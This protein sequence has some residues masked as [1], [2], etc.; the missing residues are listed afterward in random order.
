[1]NEN[2]VIV[3]TMQG[4]QTGESVKTLNKDFLTHLDTLR[5]QNKKTLA[6]V[7]I[8]TLHISDSTSEG[9]LEGRRLLSDLSIDA[10]AILGKGALAS[11]AL[12]VIRSSGV[13]RNVRFF[14]SKRKAYKWLET[15]R[16]PKPKPLRIGPLAGTAIMLIG[17]STLLGWQIHNSTLTR[18]IPSL[19]PMNPLSAIG[20]IIIGFGFFA[21][22]AKKWRWLHWGGTI[23]I[24]LGLTALLPVHSSYLLYGNRL[25]ASGA[26][27][28]VAGSAALC[29]LAMGSVAFLAG[30]KGRRTEVL[31]Y[32]ATFIVGSIA[33]FNVFGQLYAHDFIYSLGNFVMAWNLAIAFVICAATLLLL[34]LYRQLGKNVLQQVSRTGWLVMLALLAVQTATY[35]IWQ[36]AINRNHM[37][38]TQALRIRTEDIEDITASHMQAYTNSLR[39]FSGLFAASDHVSP[40]DFSTYYQSLDLAKNYPGLQS[41]IFVAAVSDANLPAF[42]AQVHR[43]GFMPD[44]KPFTIIAKTSAA[45]HFIL[46]YTA[47][48]SSANVGLDL[49]SIPNRTD[50]YNSA[51]SSNGIY[52]SGTIT[53][54]VNTPTPYQGFFLT[55]PVATAANPQPMGVVNAV[56]NYKLFFSNLFKHSNLLKDVDVSIIDS[57]NHKTVFASHKNTSSDSYSAARTLPVANQTW[58]LSVHADKTF[59]VGDGQVRAPAFILLAGQL[60]S[61]FLL[62]LFLIL[63]RARQRA[64]DL[65]DAITADL[66]VE[67]NKAVANNRKSTAILSSIG[68]GVFAIDNHRRLT[69]INPAAQEICGITEQDAVG[70]PY[71]TVLQFELEKNGKPATKFVD[72]ALAGRLTNMEEHTVLVRA[73]GKRIQVADSS[74]PIRDVRN[75]VIG[76]IIVFRDISKEYELD[77]AKNEFVSLASH[78]LRTPLS[79]INWYGEMLLSGDAGKL[80]KSQHEYVDE[81]FEGSQRMVELVNS[82]L[83]VSRLEVGKLHNEPAPTNVKELIESLE[84]ELA[85]SVQSKKLRLTKDLTALPDVTADPKQLRMIV[86]N[87][88]SNAVKYTPAK[89]SVSLTLKKASKQDVEASGLQS[90]SSYWLFSVADTGYGIPKEDQ[91]RIFSKMFRADNVRKL[92]VE[93]TGLGLYIV[94]EVVEKMGGKVWFE[95]MDS[96]GTTFYVVLPFKAKRRK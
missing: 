3:L 82:L 34:I 49:T 28:K 39:G 58:Q 4:R 44:G 85:V 66:Q 48:G 50:I 33:I 62:L 94:K 41:V 83:D 79:A 19:R 24:L 17:A 11:V 32:I 59:G 29:F 89:G 2:G 56:L 54:G 64:L 40:S 10:C 55:T 78:Q 73:D 31:E 52:G 47:T 51:L 81:I 5:E 61:A 87:L 42:I 93:G 16:V 9:R 90:G 63:W 72:Q 80:N 1:M 6:L 8:Q 23:T 95:S 88:M 77:K 13:G 27:V 18:W 22:W 65:A 25:A 21:Y 91:M 36:Q 43:D 45:R 20:I 30:R 37:Q 14:T 92:D 74:A 71:D 67:R 60:F 53:I 69:L 26:P 96:V 57:A 70:K 75:K 35:G 84:K 7:D 38:T 76:A 46:M 15:M 12:Y 86:Q 68:D